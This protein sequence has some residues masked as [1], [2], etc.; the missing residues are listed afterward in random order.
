MQ[1]FTL[2]VKKDTKA[3]QRWDLN[4]LTGAKVAA[5]EGGRRVV[6]QTKDNLSEKLEID[7][8]PITF[9]FS[10]FYL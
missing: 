4:S 9:K 5:G 10:C 6:I 8:G 7:M 3:V 2:E 1:I